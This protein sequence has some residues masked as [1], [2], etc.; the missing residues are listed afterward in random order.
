[1]PLSPRPSTT[2]HAVEADEA[3]DPGQRFDHTC[4]PS[5]DPEALITDLVFFGGEQPGGQLTNSVSCLE[6]SSIIPLSPTQGDGRACPAGGPVAPSL[7][8]FPSPGPAT[9]RARRSGGRGAAALGLWRQGGLGRG[10][11]ELCADLLCA[12]L[13][14]TSDGRV[15]VTWEDVEVEGEDPALGRDARCTRWAADYCCLTDG[16]GRERRHGPRTC[17]CLTRGG[18]RGLGGGSHWRTPRG[19]PHPGTVSGAP[20]GGWPPGQELRERGASCTTAAA[21]ALQGAA[22]R[23]SRSVQERRGGLCS[24]G[25]RGPTLQW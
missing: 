6:V 19:S 7:A 12:T 23:P 22:M 21:L 10:Q 2:W 18:R 3:L 4:C 8:P 9:R 25:K 14:R 13:E 1:M 17:G 15:Q 24:R 16:R 20:C 5:P 11:T